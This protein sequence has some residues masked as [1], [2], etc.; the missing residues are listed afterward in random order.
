M[1]TTDGRHN[2]NDDRYEFLR[3]LTLAGAAGEGL[4]KTAGDAIRQAAD[5]VGLSAVSV[6]LWDAKHELTLSVSHSV[7]EAFQQSL[8]VI[9]RDLFDSLRR[10][11]QLLTAYLSFGGEAPFQS[12]TL[13]L[14]HGERVFG[15]IVGIQAGNGKLIGEDL[16]LE[17]LSAALS[18]SIVADGAIRNASATRETLDKERL[19]AIIETAVTVNHEINNPLTAIL[20]NVQLLLLKRQD[21]DPELTNKLKTIEASAMKIRDVTQKLL[22]I[23]SARSIEYAEGTTMID[24]GNGKEESKE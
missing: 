7:S 10:H 5:L 22:R 11:R 1:T 9:E 15:A 18:L 21:L 8:Q 2:P 6:Y 19:G 13:P 4:Q 14:K 16:F 17:A 3:R 23:T 12:F 20:G 24:L